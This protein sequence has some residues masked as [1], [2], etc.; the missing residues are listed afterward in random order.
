MIT[1]EELV[2]S[3]TGWAAQPVLASRPIRESGPGDLEVAVL[4]F[5]A[6]QAVPLARDD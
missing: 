6:S 4:I 3:A 5:G 2:V 1:N